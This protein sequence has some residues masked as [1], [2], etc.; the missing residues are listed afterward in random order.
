MIT[1]T[2]ES[3]TKRNSAYKIVIVIQIVTVFQTVTKINARMEIK[4]LKTYQAHH[5]DEDHDPT[6]LEVFCDMNPDAPQCRVFEDWNTKLT[7]DS[8]LWAIH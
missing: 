2:G 7:T 5:P 8:K 3:N 1:Q 6:S 4:N